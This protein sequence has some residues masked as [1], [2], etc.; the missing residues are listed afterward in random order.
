MRRRRSRRTRGSAASSPTRPIYE[1][2]GIPSV[3]YGPGPWRYEPDEYIELDE[4]LDA[5]RIYYATA[6][7]LGARPEAEHPLPRYIDIEF[8][9]EQVTARALLL[10]DQAPRTCQRIWEI[11]PLRGRVTHARYSG[12]M[13]AHHFDN[14]VVIEAENHTTYIQTGDVIYTHYAAGWRHGNPERAVRGLLGL[15]PVR[16][17][18]DPGR[19]HALHGERLRHVHRRPDALLRGLRAHADRGREADRDPPRRRSGLRRPRGHPATPA[20]R[21]PVL[22]GPRVAGTATSPRPHRR[23]RRP[24]ARRSSLGT[25]VRRRNPSI[26]FTQHCPR[27]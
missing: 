17:A 27:W 16:A 26:G 4:L 12:T 14:T 21:R 20:W 9:N 18:D 5:A 3:V 23:L 6:L 2:H 7:L 10:D 15:R 25:L 13:V 1:E 8:T 24:S 19:R 22:F 11:L